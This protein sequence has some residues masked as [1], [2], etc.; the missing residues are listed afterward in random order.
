MNLRN[1]S[2]DIL[3]SKPQVDACG[4]YVS[5]S[6]LLL[7]GI[8]TAPGVEEVDGIAMAEQVGMHVPLKPCAASCPS[9]NPVSPLLGEVSTFARISNEKFRRFTSDSP[10][11]QC[12]VLRI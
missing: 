11:L 2:F 4:V 10:L 12:S 6:K 1:L 3:V 9:D 5:M 8:Q 7:E